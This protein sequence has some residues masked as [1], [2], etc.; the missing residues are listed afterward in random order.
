[1]MVYFIGAG[2]GDPK[3]IT[4]KAKETIKKADII[5]YA[6]SLVNREI[7]KFSAK[8]AR[9]YDSSKMNLEE[10]VK[11]IGKA[12]SDGKIVAR[13]HS[14][15]PSLYGAIQE[16]M[17][18]CKKNNIPFEVIPGVSSFCAAAAA[19]KQELTLPGIS[20]TVIITRLS[21]R[22]KV[23]PKEDL[24][25]L[26]KIKATLVIFLSV[27]LIDE[28]VKRLL[29]G[30][31]KATPAAIVYRAS[32]KDQKIIRGKLKDLASKAKNEKIKSQ[33]LIFV[34]GVLKGSGFEKSKLYDKNFSHAFRKKMNPAPFKKS[35]K[36]RQN[37]GKGAE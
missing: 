20:Q 31:P 17:L 1:M 12:A 22:T 2:P 16:Q 33:A 14:G 35:K 25:R 13:I 6:G 21:G 9:A 34:G 26:S 10:V 11:V 5:I 27:A 15:D 4:V 32:W 36:Q 19:L 24:R 23:P 37:K 8:S 30:Y 29:S 3:L 7:L 18:W 28:V